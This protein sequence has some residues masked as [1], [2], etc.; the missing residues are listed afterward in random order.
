MN[1]PID[2]S[3]INAAVTAL[4]NGGVIAYPTEAVFGLGCDPQN[5]T[6]I[7]KLLQ[8]KHRS[9]KK[10]LILIASDW[11]QIKPYTAAI[12]PKKLA[13][14]FS[15]WPG[16]IT[17]VFPSSELTP[18][19][20]RGE[21]E[22]VAVRVTAHPTAQAIC[23]RFDGPIVSTSANIED[24][25]AARDARTV[26]LTFKD[27]LEHIVTDPVGTDSIRPT[28]IRDAITGEVLRPA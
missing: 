7:G 8:L 9:I 6:A 3:S 25:P 17:W 1:S 14:V 20:V 22:T 27:A 24:F 5:P 16:P 4:Q 18:L 19:W 15:S 21:H 28:E 12:D 13:R 10:G 26:K 11:E 23:E 2:Y